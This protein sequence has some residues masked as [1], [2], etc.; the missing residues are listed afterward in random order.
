MVLKVKY[1]FVLLL[2]LGKDLC[3][4]SLITSVFIDLSLIVSTLARYDKNPEQTKKHASRA[5]KFI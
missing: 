1:V 2:F 3:L 4:R 5:R